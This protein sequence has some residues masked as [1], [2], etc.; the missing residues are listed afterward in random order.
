MQHPAYIKEVGNAN[1][2]LSDALAKILKLILKVGRLSII[3]LI[4][5]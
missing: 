5:F 4:Q 3:L 1:L 2:K